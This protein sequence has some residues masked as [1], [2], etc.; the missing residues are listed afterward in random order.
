M[1]V[2]VVGGTGMCGS[3]VVAELRQRGH[4]PRV[5]SRNAGS[6]PDHHQVDLATG[7]GLPSALTG[8][9]AVIDASN[10]RN[11][12]AMRQVLIAGTERLLRAEADAG[13]SHHVLPSIVGVDVVRLGYY[14]IKLEQE[15]VAL[16]G[17]VPATVVRSTQF[18]ELLDE[19]LAKIARFGVL[20]RLAVPVQPIAARDAAVA[21][22]DAAERGPGERVDVAG[23]EIMSVTELARVWLRG[24][25]RRRPLVPLLVPGKYGRA[26]RA[27]AL[28]APDA[29]RGTVR[30]VEW[31]S[32]R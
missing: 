22:V 26:M 14:G 24:M 27:G 7:A 3:A 28:T 11:S 23:P 30:F 25:S 13:V 1:Q 15:Q 2:A 31:I 18:H 19:F 6:A 32:T 17:P 21:M 5:L 20:P 10:T 8:A 12:R 16:R 9:D 4:Q 29:R